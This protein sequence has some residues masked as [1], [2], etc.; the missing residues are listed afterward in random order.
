MPLPPSVAAQLSGKSVVVTRHEKPGFYALTPGKAA[1]GLIGAGAATGAGN[2]IVEENGVAD[3]A[4]VLV[5]ALAPAIVERY[6]LQWDPSAT[7]VVDT[8]KVR[9]IAAAHSG[10]DYVLDVQSTGWNYAYHANLKTYWVG[11]SVEVQ[12]IDVKSGAAASKMAC[13]SNTKKHT[14]EP[15]RDEFVENQAQLLKD[16]TTHLGWVCVQLLAKEQFGLSPEV[17]PAIPESYV[18]PL[19]AYAAAHPERLAE[20]DTKESESSPHR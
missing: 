10:V 11:Y 19:T 17:T 14:V 16:V 4:E 7:A 3:P 13:D 8:K 9:E 18:D 5:G 6:G 15:T 12:L 2:K 20:K 1:F